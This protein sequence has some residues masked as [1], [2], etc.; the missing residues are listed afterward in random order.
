MGGLS[1]T[2]ENIA[3]DALLGSG[4]AA[5]MPATVYLALFSVICTDSS[6]GTELSGDAYAR[7]AIT[8]NDTNFP[9]AA[10]GSKSNGVAIEFPEA[11]AD[12][13]EALGWALLD[14]ITDSAASNIIFHNE[15][16]SG[17][18]ILNGN[19]ATFPIGTL[20]FGAD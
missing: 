18:T 12:W 9:A 5:A 2:Y 17:K 8:N 14:H 11:T 10:S 13:D 4:K 1:E 20:V 15:F 19:T 7:V 6:F 3:L 16:D